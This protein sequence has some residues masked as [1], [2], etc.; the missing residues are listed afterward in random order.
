MYSEWSS[1][2]VITV[3]QDSETSSLQ[4]EDDES[5]TINLSRSPSPD[6]DDDDDSEALDEEDSMDEKDDSE[7]EHTDYC[8]VCKDGGELLCCDKCPLAYHLEC[9][10]PPLKKIPVGEWLCQKCTVSTSLYIF[11]SF[12]YSTCTCMYM[13]TLQ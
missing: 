9:A 7:G 12:M 6:D 8:F 10:F 3:G 5:G 11:V 13:Y 4:M 1:L 2:P